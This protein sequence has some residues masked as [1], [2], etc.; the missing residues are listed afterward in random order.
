MATAKRNI[1]R[2]SGNVIKVSFP[3]VK[4]GFEQ[5]IQ[6]SGDRHFDSARSDRDLQKTDL[7]EAIK[8]DALIVDIGD[9][10]DAMQG[11]NDPRSDYSELRPEYVGAG[12]YFNLIV[13]DAAKFFK[14]YASNFL[15]LGKGNHETSVTKK[16]NVD[17][18]SMLAGELQKTAKNEIQ[19]GGYGGYIKFGFTI[20]GTQMRSFNLK[21][22]HGWGGGGPV[23]RGVID[24]HRQAVFLPDAH[25]VVNGHTHD[26]YY[27]AIPRERISQ[28]GTIYTDLAHFIRTPTYKDDYGDGSGGWNVETGKPP[29]PR[30]CVWLRFYYYR[31]DIAIQVIPDLR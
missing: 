10:F 3:N 8:R 9:L 31:G 13:S 19:V 7:D 26:S 5:W 1:E 17:L 2:K 24:T 28:A 22:M 23:T 30:G 6:L 15:M 20:Q 14:P 21:Y 18:T 29:K 12:N 16:H 27:V 25:I 11:R 4:D